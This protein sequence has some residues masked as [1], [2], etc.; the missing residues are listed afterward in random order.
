LKVKND[1]PLA[2]SNFWA[3]AG[4]GRPR[5]PKSIWKKNDEFI[6]DPPHEFQGWYSIY[7]S[8]LSTINIIKNFASKFNNM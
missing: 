7:N 8:D 4:F 3:W 6:G 2:G 1:S 5:K